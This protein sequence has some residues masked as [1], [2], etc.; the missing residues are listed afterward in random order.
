MAD[1]RH[2]RAAVPEA[3]LGRLTDLA[4]AHLPGGA[5][6][7]AVDDPS[8]LRVR[9]RIATDLAELSYD[10]YWRQDENLRYVEFTAHGND[11]VAVLLRLLGQAI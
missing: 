7:N 5:A 8:Y 10:W 3:A 9:Q 11:F 6:V 2:D 1:P 4:R